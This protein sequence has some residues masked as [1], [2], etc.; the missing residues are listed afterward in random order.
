MRQIPLERTDSS[1]VSF[2]NYS[3]N[4]KDFYYG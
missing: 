3:N 1:E 4:L 2:S